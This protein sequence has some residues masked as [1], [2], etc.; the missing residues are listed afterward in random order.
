MTMPPSSSRSRS[1]ARPS[2]AQPP[3]RL[4]ERDPRQPGGERRLAAEALERGEGA[5]P[6][7][8]HHVL[9][10]GVVAQDAAG[11]AEEPPVVAA[12]QLADRRLV[13]AGGRAR[14]GRSS[15]SSSGVGEA[16]ELHHAHPRPGT[17]PRSMIA[18]T[19]GKPASAASGRSPAAPRVVD[20]GIGRR[21][22]D[23]Q[24]A[25][26][27]RV[28]V[29]H[30][31]VVVDALD[32]QRHGKTLLGQ[33]IVRIPRR[34]SRR[35]APRPREVRRMVGGRR[36]GVAGVDVQPAHGVAGTQPE[37]GRVEADM[38]RPRRRRACGW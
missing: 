10:L 25:D 5:H 15:G 1:T 24:P 28:L 9:R 19:E 21:I 29:R 32:G 13:A 22:A 23:D 17:M 30:A 11:G 12:D 2:P 26:H 31:E 18:A 33:K 4:V 38:R 6:G 8:L 3:E 7:R 37:A 16:G 20:P 34:R 14:R 36:M 35:D 27:A